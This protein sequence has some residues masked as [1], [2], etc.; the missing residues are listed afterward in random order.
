MRNRRLRPPQR[1]LHVAGAHLTLRRDHRQEPKP[2]RI[3]QR[4]EYQSQLGRHTRGDL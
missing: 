1:A 4:R 2:H 3:S